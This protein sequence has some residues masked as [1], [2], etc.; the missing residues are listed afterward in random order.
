MAMV[1][2]GLRGLPH[3]R[4]VEPQGNP[5]ESCYLRSS[6]TLPWMVP[7]HLERWSDGGTGRNSLVAGIRED[8]Q[9]LLE[10]LVP[11]A[12]MAPTPGP[13]LYVWMV[14]GAIRT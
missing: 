11:R 6:Q 3:R 2:M 13:V 9:R 8:P 14:L 12:L 1:C 7:T 4:A 5:R 10:T